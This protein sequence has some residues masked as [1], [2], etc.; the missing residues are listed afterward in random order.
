MVM[1]MSVSVKPTSDL[2]F[3]AQGCALNSFYGTVTV[4]GVATDNIVV[5]LTDMTNGAASLT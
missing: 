3:A 4:N 2:T 1:L 5:T